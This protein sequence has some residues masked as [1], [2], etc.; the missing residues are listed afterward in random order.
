MSLHTIVVHLDQKLHDW[1]LVEPLFHKAERLGTLTR[2]GA[3]SFQS[4][5]LSFSEIESMEIKPITDGKYAVSSFVPT[6]R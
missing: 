3:P 6:C 2:L 1:Y 4:G 5:M